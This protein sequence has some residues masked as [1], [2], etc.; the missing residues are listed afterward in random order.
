MGS[1]ITRRV[2]ARRVLNGCAWVAILDATDHELLR[3]VQERDS[4]RAV[5]G[6]GGGGVVGYNYL[7]SVSALGQAMFRSRTY[8]ALNI[9]VDRPRPKQINVMVVDRAGQNRKF[10]NE[11]HQRFA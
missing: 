4:K 6:R 5:C 10:V 3:L 2:L 1:E 11:V 8:A 9:P 7:M